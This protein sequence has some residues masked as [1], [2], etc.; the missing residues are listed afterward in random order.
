MLLE[1]LEDNNVR[2]DD[3][4]AGLRTQ[5]SQLRK[6]AVKKA[7]E[8]QA[9]VVGLENEELKLKVG[10]LKKKLISLE[11]QNGVQQIPLP[12]HLK[13]A[14][15]QP[16]TQP[17]PTI[18]QPKPTISHPTTQPKPTTQSTPSEDK[19]EVPSEQKDNNEDM[20]KKSKKN[21][22]EK[23]ETP[24]VPTRE[25]DVSM[26]DMR[27]GRVVGVEKHSD[28]DSLYVEEVDVGEGAKRTIVSGLVAYVPIEQMKDRLAVFLL[29]LKPAKMRGILSQGMIMCASTPQ[30][31]EVIEVPAGAEV[32]D[33]V[34]VDEYPGNPEEL[35]NPKKKVWEAIQPDLRINMDGLASYK[36]KLWKIE[37]KG[38][39]HAPSLKDTPI[40]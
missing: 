5:L 15:K 40:K 26:L 3:M 34:V 33:R 38:S 23:A 37:G 32:G 36:G 4:L 29:N 12:D 8:E 39:F 18:S 20:K 35:L 7:I 28:A 25:I 21:K 16:T 1:T 6:H 31:V 2:I 14:V 11:T 10:L 27:V 9:R 30:K 13:H 17:K 19:S 22:S 24:K